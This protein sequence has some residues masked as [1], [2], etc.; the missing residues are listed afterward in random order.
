MLPIIYIIIYLE[1]S[2][3]KVTFMIKLTICVYYNVNIKYILTFDYY[4]CIKIN[5]PILY[6]IKYNIKC[7]NNYKK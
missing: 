6:F 5:I 7:H 2:S 1:S 4:V 3:L